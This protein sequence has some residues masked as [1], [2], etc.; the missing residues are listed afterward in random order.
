MIDDPNDTVESFPSNGY[1]LGIDEGEV[2]LLAERR[3][4]VY[5]KVTPEQGSQRLSVIFEQLVPGDEIPIHLHEDADEVLFIH[6][7]EGIERLGENEHGVR[8]G[9]IIYVPQGTWHSL[10][11]TSPTENLNVLAVFSPP[12]FEGFF[13]VC[14]TSPG[15][16]WVEPSPEEW[17]EIRRRFKYKIP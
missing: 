10:R 7:G 16:A 17:T 14:G 4:P 12:G 15:Q 13:R 3:A 5:L 8:A 2:F 9:S 1:V 6:S 11:N